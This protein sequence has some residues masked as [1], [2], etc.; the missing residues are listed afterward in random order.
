[1]FLFGVV[2]PWC[3][4]V[5]LRALFFMEPFMPDLEL[6]QVCIFL[7]SSNFFMFFPTISIGYFEK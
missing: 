6:S 2:I 4:P 3:S 1:M 5:S 7:V